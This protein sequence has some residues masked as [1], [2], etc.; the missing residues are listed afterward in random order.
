MGKEEMAAAFSDL[1][2]KVLNALMDN[3]KYNLTKF[4]KIQD[5]IHTS[6][7]YTNNINIIKEE[8]ANTT[9]SFNKFMEGIEA[10]IIDFGKKII[11]DNSAWTTGKIIKDSKTFV[12][13]D[14][15]KT[16]YE[17]IVNG[18]ITDN[19]SIVEVL[20]KLEMQK[21]NL[22]NFFKTDDNNKTTPTGLPTGPITQ[23]P[24]STGPPGQLQQP[25]G[26]T[27][28]PPGSTGPPPGSTG[29]PTG[30][31]GQPVETNA[32]QATVD[33]NILYITHKNGAYS[34]SNVLTSDA[35]KVVKQNDCWTIEGSST[36]VNN[37]NKTSF[38]FPSL[39]FSLFKSNK[40]EQTEEEKKSDDRKNNIE[41][42]TEAPKIGG[43]PKTKKRVQKRRGFKSRSKK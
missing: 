20:K 31:P 36:V 38:S 17:N 6:T 43:R 23:P 5:K 25:P 37:K 41:N 24:G 28:P 40:R 27:G 10:T 1:K 29:P 12:E 30:P 3:E 22:E 7:D 42:K 8:N 18:D 16:L 15:L 9:V 33:P 13:L 39:P 32:G 26:S 14:K 35:T 21:E 4:I 11:P 19:A 34:V 2:I